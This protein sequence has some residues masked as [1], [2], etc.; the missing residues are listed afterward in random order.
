MELER[1]VVS[2]GA[3]SSTG[4]FRIRFH[5][6]KRKAWPARLLAN[7]RESLGA[8]VSL[9]NACEPA[10]SL[11][12]CVSLLS[13]RVPAGTDVVVV[14]YAQNDNRPTIEDAREGGASVDASVR[15]AAE[16]FLVALAKLAASRHEPPPAVVFFTT[17]LPPN[18]HRP[19]KAPAFKDW[20]A[21]WSDKGRARAYAT[22]LHGHA[23]IYDRVAH[24]HGASSFALQ[25]HDALWPDPNPNPR[26]DELW[27]APDYKGSDIDHHPG[28]AAHEFAA[29][30][31]HAALVTLVRRAERGDDAVAPDWF[32][33]NA[34][35]SSANEL[36][37]LNACALG[38]AAH[39]VAADLETKAAGDPS[40]EVRASGGW[41][42]KRDRPTKPPGW[43]VDGAADESSELV[44][45]VPC[46]GARTI[47]L[48][49]LMS[50]ER[51]GSVS[52]SFKTIHV[53]KVKFNELICADD[54]E[55]AA[56]ATAP[57]SSPLV[58]SIEMRKLNATWPQAESL[59][60]VKQFR[61]S[62]RNYAMWWNPVVVTVK[63]D[64]ADQGKF[65]LLSVFSC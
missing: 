21:L 26:L 41:V 12:W 18:F 29:D 50:Y 35:L 59:A 63:P 22:V 64:P 31:A 62:C 58:S 17:I 28:L 49:F 39:H 37:E 5:N 25:H 23:R 11:G 65:K 57:R 9:H 19:N 2:S 15:V 10:S 6:D 7:L 48:E 3:P 32:P 14:D 8:G 60:V 1:F 45:V 53:D 30:A 33:R 52:I 54:T 38:M 4:C 34:T 42:L 13:T 20:R 51:M 61:V 40:A 56:Y 43:I 16:A 36:A 46:G 44:F 27:R 55:C 47:G 24:F